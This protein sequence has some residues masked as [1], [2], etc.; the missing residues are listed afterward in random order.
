[1]A[2]PLVGLRRFRE[3]IV[4]LDD[5][6]QVVKTRGDVHVLGTWIPADGWDVVQDKTHEDGTSSYRLVRK[7]SSKR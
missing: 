7:V 3:S 4:T 5:I 6:V 1:M 2:I